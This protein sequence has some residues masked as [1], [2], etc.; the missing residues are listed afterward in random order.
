M[1]LLHLRN[2]T[3][4]FGLPPVLNKIN[5]SLDRRERVC[6]VGRNGAGKSTLMKLIAGEIKP[7]GGEIAIERG[8]KIAQLAQ[9]VPK[10]INGKVLAL[11]ATELP[12]VEE[13][14]IQQR[15]SELLSRLA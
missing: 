5:F 13:W 14:L 10:N 3:V 12:N 7:D 15:A 4:S 6:L 11:L 8:I 1:T 2:I 9:E